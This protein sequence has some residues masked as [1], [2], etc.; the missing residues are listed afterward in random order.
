M[1]QTWTIH[2]AQAAS[3]GGVVACQHYEA[4]RAGARVLAAG[5]NA[6]D[7]A[8]VATLVLGVVEPWLGGI[9]GGGF[10][11]HDPGDG[12]A[13]ET[14]DFN[15]RAASGLDPSDYPLSRGAGG[16]WFDW[17]A[18][19]GDRNLRG[20]GAICV[21]GAVAGLAEGLER[22]GT[23]SWTDA[24]A[25][26]IA[27]A[28]RGLEMDWFARLCLAIDAPNLRRDPHAAAL[29]LDCEQGGE[30]DR[31]GGAAR[32]RPMPGLARVMRRLA[33]AGARDFY[34]GEIARSIVADLRVGGSAIGAADLAGYRAS[35]QAPARLDYRG[36]EIVTI[37]GLSGGPSLLQALE[38]LAA[39]G[40]G[41]HD[42][43]RG[44]TDDDDA[45]PGD[46][47]GD[48]DGDAGS[49]GG[50]LGRNPA[51]PDAQAALVH[52]RAIRHAYR[53]RLTRMGHAAAGGDC[54]THVSVVDRHGRMVALTNTLLSRFG[55]KVVLPQTG[56]LL[57]NAMM[58]FDPRPGTPNAIAPG[59]E[60]LANM[61]PCIVRHDRRPV[62]ALG[63]AGGR[64][65]FPTL[66]QILSFCLDYGMTLEE[67]FHH[68]R[69]DASTP[70]IRVNRAAAPDVA[71]R[72][73]SEFP[74]E[75]V[76]DTLYP[77]NFAVPSAVAR[78]WRAGWNFGMAHP[79]SPWAYVA[80]EAA[81]AVEG[82]AD[83]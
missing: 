66:V 33:E 54:T 77:V 7:A 48:G 72:I 78:D 21:P 64:Q 32:F 53:N 50:P 27:L 5:G 3:T 2:K 25:P 52:A 20:Y 13:V 46:G 17:P 15:M 38:Q 55:A 43:N 83:G 14:L 67:A 44:D 31:A 73:G 4:A 37:G 26:A 79:T 80:S 22:L 6:M 23:L 10:L 12:G 58:W 70:T 24:L 75:L 81:A 82:A 19:E 49:G 1:T 45:D 74:V 16:N 34:E 28:E 11:V 71:A 39:A 63:A 40:P 41:G 61:A 76:S 8:V 56:F 57:N 29:F 30:S 51:R 36:H 62:M 65:I 69:I 60:P 35:W 59:A 9:G 42:G 68:P 47:D 18:V